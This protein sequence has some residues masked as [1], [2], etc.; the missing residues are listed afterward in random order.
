MKQAIF[1]RPLTDDERKQLEAGFRSSD[2]F[3][4]RRCQILLASA[5]G[6]WPPKIAKNLGCDPQTFRNAIHAFNERWASLCTWS[7]SRSRKTTL[8]RRPLKVA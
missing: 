3:V 5:R 7:S 8:T 4:L 1:V 6:E 2:A